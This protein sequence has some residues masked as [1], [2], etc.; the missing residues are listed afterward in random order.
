MVSKEQ[1]VLPLKY[2]KEQELKDTQCGNSEVKNTS[3]KDYS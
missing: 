2:L 3:S 1:C